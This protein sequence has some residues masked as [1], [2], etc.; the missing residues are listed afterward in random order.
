MMADILKFTKTP[1][2]NESIEEYKY[3]EYDPI[4]GPILITVVISELVS[5][6]KT[7]SLIL[8]RDT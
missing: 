3:H 2:I 5:N 4:T 1:N 7:C 6:R 8:A